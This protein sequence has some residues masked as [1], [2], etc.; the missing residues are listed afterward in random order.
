[1]IRETQMVTEGTHRAAIEMKL[2]APLAWVVMSAVALLLLLLV[3]LEA[4]HWLQW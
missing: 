1:M 2:R 3:L 4:G